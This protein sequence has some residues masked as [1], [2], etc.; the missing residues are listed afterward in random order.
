MGLSCL[1]QS[2]PATGYGPITPGLT[3]I[4]VKI[5]TGLLYIWMPTLIKFQCVWPT[6][7][8]NI[9]LSW[10]QVSIFIPSHNSSKTHHFHPLFD[11]QAIHKVLYTLPKSQAILSTNSDTVHHCWTLL[12]PIWKSTSSH[13]SP[14]TYHI[15]L[16]LWPTLSVTGTTLCLNF[17]P[18]PTTHSLVLH[19]WF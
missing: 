8:W 1:V 5:C 15:L 16:K 4:I 9:A 11:L 7:S 13:I 6:G 14:T 18:N 17:Q 12:H 19:T 2:S 10:S 3:P